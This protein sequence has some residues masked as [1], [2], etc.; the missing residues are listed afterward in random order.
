[1]PM[2]LAEATPARGLDPD[3]VPSGAVRAPAMAPSPERRSLLG[4]T[5]LDLTERVA[6][7]GL[8]A[9]L[10]ARL[11]ANFWA[12]REAG[13]LL[14]LPSEGLLILFLLIRRRTSEVSRRPGE[15]A[16][17]LAASCAP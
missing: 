3:R 9:W 13:S 16:L 6:L 14:L 5:C 4:D 12:T 15:W 1:M 7:I 2:N 17:A 11:L 10:V 8:Y